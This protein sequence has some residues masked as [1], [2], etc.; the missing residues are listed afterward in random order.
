MQVFNGCINRGALWRQVIRECAVD[1]GVV[2]SI[3][4]DAKLSDLRQDF[5][6]RITN[7]ENW[8]D[9]K[10]RENKCDEGS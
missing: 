6:N 2:Y 10:R 1:A 3:E 8:A 7:M 9:E 4:R 5:Y